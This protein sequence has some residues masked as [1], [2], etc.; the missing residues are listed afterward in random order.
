[1]GGGFNHG[2]EDAMVLTHAL[3]YVRHPDFALV[4]CVDPLES[5]RRDFMAKWGVRSGYASIEEALQAEA[6]DIASVCSPTGTHLAALGVLAESGVRAV[7]AEKPLDGDTDGARRLAGRYAERGVPV[8]VNFTRRFDPA[9]QALRSEI[10]DQRYG[11]LRQ[12]C[13]WYGRG[14]MN[15]GSHLL[16]LVAFLTGAGIRLE[17]IGPSISDGVEGDPTVSASLVSGDVKFD[18][19]GCDGRDFARFEIELGFSDA[20]V[21]IEDAG[22]TIRRRPVEASA[23]AGRRSATTG[24]WQSTRY[25]EAMLMALT[26]LRQWNSVRRLSSDIDSAIPALALAQQIRHAALGR[27]SSTPS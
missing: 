17:S 8:A 12:V 22:Q 26:E 2:I 5:A 25:G 11:R 4:A 27:T 18:L 14:I 21:M 9:M 13:G 15:N 23:F 3:A 16:D 10:A 24:A 19:I 6:Y 20:I 1:M 7:F